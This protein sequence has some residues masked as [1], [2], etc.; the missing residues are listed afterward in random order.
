MQESK[1]FTKKFTNQSLNI[2]N[3]DISTELPFDSKPVLNRDDSLILK[4]DNSLPPF[5]ADSK[6]LKKVSS[7]MTYLKRDDSFIGKKSS[8]END[9]KFSI[10]N[11]FV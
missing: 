10:D 6:F 2:T 9:K 5:K 1:L 3:R 7:E 11:D 8:L 4:K